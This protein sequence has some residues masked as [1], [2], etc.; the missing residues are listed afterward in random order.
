MTL[1]PE[2]AFHRAPRPLLL[3]VG[4]AA[5]VLAAVGIGVFLF[6][7]GNA[8]AMAYEHAAAVGTGVPDMSGGLPAL[9]TAIVGFLGMLLPQVLNALT[10][11]NRERR[12]H[13]ARGG[14]PAAPFDP[15]PPQG[16]RP[17][18]SP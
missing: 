8:I 18:D 4:V 7:V 6:R 14:G 3:W 17:G 1:P 2:G 15:S 9:I 11:R 10:A 16:P 13:I 12:D 5:A